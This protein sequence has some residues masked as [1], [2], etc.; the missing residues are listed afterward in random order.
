MTST[1]TDIDECTKRLE[2]AIPRAEVTKEVNRTYSRLAGQVK[3]KGFRQGKVPRRILEQY[4][5]EEVQAE[6][7]TRVISTSYRDLL[8]KKG[9]RAVG[10]ANVTDIV[11][12]D[13]SADLTYKATVEVIPPFEM[14]EYKG[15]EIEVA[16]HPVT[17]EMIEDQ[18][19]RF[20]MQAAS[21]EDVERASEA[22]DY[23]TFDIAGFE[24][25]APVPDTDRKNEALLLGGG[26]NEKELE[27]ALIGM[28]PGEE[29]DFEVDIP[30]EGPPNMAGK[31]LRFHLKVQS[32]KEPHPPALD[33]EFVR[34][35][36]GGLSS[37]DEFRAQIK[38]EIETQEESTVHQQG[39]SLLLS[40]LTEM[41]SFEVPTSLVN[42]EAAERIAEYERQ[43]G[44]ENPNLEITTGQR[45]QMRE[46]I[47]PQAAE[48]VRQ[49]IL[50]D[51]IRESEGLEAG[52]GEVDA[53]LVGL[54]VRYQM[55]PDQL[56]ERMEATGGM[57]SFVRNIN[58]NKTVDWL[59]DQA[60]VDVKIEE[61]GVAEEAQA[62]PEESEESK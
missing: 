5:G 52:P 40:K 8:E 19:K 14:G 15:I 12:D 43:A 57:E 56:R 6:V 22:E 39:V 48:R 58:Y 62:A 4:Y 45:E 27:E 44:Q 9:M 31:T 30:K 42:S 7:V 53:H 20:L 59:Y 26:R 28:K 34:A 24:G 33:D 55:E 60:K 49:M 11:N 1:I 51:R 21:Y 13:D 54:A 41:Y 25:D 3:I 16:S 36:G 23:I 37:V 61:D 46:S 18:I 47:L 2:V 29:K 50:I 35:L 17:G 32:I 10:E 38:K